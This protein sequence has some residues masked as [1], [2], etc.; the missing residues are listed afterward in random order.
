MRSFLRTIAST[1]LVVAIFGVILRQSLPTW[2]AGDANARPWAVK[3]MNAIGMT[4]RVGIDRFTGHL[5][6]AGFDESSI[7]NS[8]NWGTGIVMWE[9]GIFSCLA[10]I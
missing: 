6:W 2:S 7:G 4:S 8:E 5:E 10:G 9:R 1:A 3:A